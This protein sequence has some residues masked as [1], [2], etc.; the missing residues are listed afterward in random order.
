MKRNLIQFICIDSLDKKLRSKMLS[1]LKKTPTDI[2]FTF[3]NERYI[4]RLFP[5]LVKLL[6]IQ[7][8]FRR[9]FILILP[10]KMSSFPTEE[11]IEKCILVVAQAGVNKLTAAQIEERENMRLLAIKAKKVYV[12]SESLIGEFTAL[13]QNTF[14]LSSGLLI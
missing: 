7:P 2:V 5:W 6:S 11:Q 8:I 4:R 1:T 12:H 14:M 13:N 10:L 9:T 3:D